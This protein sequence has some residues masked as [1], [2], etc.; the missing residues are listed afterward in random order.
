MSR[1]K[2]S[3]N[4]RTMFLSGIAAAALF[5]VTVGIGISIVTGGSEPASTP[6]ESEKNSVSV[7]E[8]EPSSVVEPSSEEEPSSES[9][10]VSEASSSEAPASS[11]TAPSS[12][13]PAASSSAPASSAPAA[14]S[15]LTGVFDASVYTGSG[16]SNIADYQKINSDV[17]GWLKVPGTNINYPVLHH[18]TDIN[19]YLE[20]DLYKQWSKN[21]V[22]WASPTVKFGSSS[23]IS[24]NTVLFGHNWTNVSANPRV[25]YSSDVMFAQLTSYHHLNFAKQYPYVYYSTSDEAMTWKIFAAFYTDIGF[26]YV[27]PNPGE[28]SFEDI[29]DGA[30]A[31]SR[32]DFDVDVDTD[33]KILTLSTCTRAY[34][35]SDRQRF[36]VM[37]RLLRPGEEIE[38]VTV[39]TNPNPILPK[40]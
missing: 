13:A 28:S 36:V 27:E 40:L 29:I 22:I 32:H 5:A 18:S 35:S 31:R 9:E 2:A 1:K 37:A 8:S 21:G 15:S 7:Y 19:Y 33:D 14:S 16:Q 24:D 25:G 10:P 26:N 11:S 4:A 17:K 12:S 23:K 30:K 20:R 39:T 3:F 34:G 38:A 6:S